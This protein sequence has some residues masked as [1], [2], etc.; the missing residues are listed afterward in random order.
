ME[1]GEQN[2][3]KINEFAKIIGKHYNTV[4]LWFKRLEEKGL[5]YIQRVANEK[6]YDDLDVMIGKF[7]LQKREEKWSHDAIHDELAYNHEL[8][9]FPDGEE[10]INEVLDVEKIK[11]QI[12]EEVQA[13]TKEAAATELKEIKM[14][15]K[16][17]LE[18]VQTKY[19]EVMKRLPDPNESKDREV[20]NII[21][22]R[23]IEAQLRQE[24]LNKW[25]QRP[26]N[27]RFIK[28]GLFSKA[29]DVNKRDRFIEE[30]ISNH[31]EERLKQEYSN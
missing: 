13:V 26:L 8:R 1:Y 3:Y 4:D 28:V 7:I 17:R 31:F 6:V 22:K 10:P 15:Y 18:E 11:R 2:F 27:D 23:R 9:P 29:E 21:T 19:E 12:L 20:T 25:E 24:A 30:Y 14:E 16:K 5:H